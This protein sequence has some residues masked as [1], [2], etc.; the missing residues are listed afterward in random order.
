MLNSLVIIVFASV[1][2]IIY[3]VC[4]S[5]VVCDVILC[6]SSVRDTGVMR[7]GRQ[8]KWRRQT[9]QPLPL[10]SPHT[11]TSPSEPSPS[12]MYANTLMFSKIAMSYKNA[13]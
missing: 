5:D 9:S 13:R 7:W 10:A 12:K 6:R 8:W 2:F 1:C 4:V 3:H 11:G